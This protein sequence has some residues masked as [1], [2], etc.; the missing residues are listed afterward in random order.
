MS[1]AGSAS[2][3]LSGRT[4]G[5]AGPAIAEMGM[6]DG[7]PSPRSAVGHVLFRNFLSLAERCGHTREIINEFPA[8]SAVL[9]KG[10]A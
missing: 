7:A 8:P 2:A 4:A 9:S 1:S 5:A 6:Q 3:E 10:C